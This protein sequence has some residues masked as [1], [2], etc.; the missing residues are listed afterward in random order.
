MRTTFEEEWWQR[1][2]RRVLPRAHA[3]LGIVQVPLRQSE[4]TPLSTQS[5]KQRL[6]KG[7]RS[8][9]LFIYSWMSLTCTSNLSYCKSNAQ[10]P[11][12]SLKAQSSSVSLVSV[13]KKI[14]NSWLSQ[15]S[16]WIPDSSRALTTYKFCS[17]MDRFLFLL[18]HSIRYISIYRCYILKII[19]RI[20][21]I[22]TSSSVDYAFCK[23]ET[24]S[25]FYYH[26]LLAVYIQCLV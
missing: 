15:K 1:A 17:C 7:H 4:Q 22:I 23:I 24:S 16:G 18:Y 21:L 11:P 9:W 26:Y 20:C 5:F 6:Q 14:F 25:A 3:G 13:S 8:H 19:L 12:I 10:F 2:V